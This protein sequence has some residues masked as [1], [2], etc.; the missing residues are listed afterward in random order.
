[1]SDAEV[2]SRA[3][4]LANEVA[5]TLPRV[6]DSTTTVTGALFV[7]QTKTFIYQYRT[8]TNLD[9]EKM[10]QYLPAMTC[11]DPVR[12]SY[13]RRGIIFRHEYYTPTGL[14]AMNVGK[15]ECEKY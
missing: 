4:Y 6:A 11:G 12:K 13:V 15:K 3:T 7:P 9:G 10:K 14:V 8:N 1:M 2:V 5:K